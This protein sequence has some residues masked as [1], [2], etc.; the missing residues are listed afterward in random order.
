[1][2][3]T[4]RREWYNVERAV[5]TVYR[6]VP[7][8]DVHIGARACDEALFRSVVKR[9]AD[10]PTCYWLG[11]GD[12]CDLI[13]VRDPRA[14][15]ETLAD[16]ITVSDLVDVVQAQREHFLD[17]VRPIAHKCLGLIEGNHERAIRHHYERDVYSEIV[18]EIKRAGEFPADHNLAFG[19]YGWLQL[20]FYWASNKSG[21]SRTV[22]GNLHHGFSGGKLKGGKALNMERWL[23]THECDFAVFGHSHNADIFKVAVESIDRYGRVQV[24]TRIGGYA[25]TFLRTVNDGGACT[26]SERAGYFP[27]PTGGIEMEIRPALEPGTN[28]RMMT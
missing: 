19:V 28:V 26:Y 10:D 25:G 23:W 24:S 11:I 7:V 20:A 22:T 5:D 12:Y 27:L 4:I 13:N 21:G 6:V 9:I 18:T 17:I 16:W 8:G 14:D 2:S 3:R 1:M 15:L